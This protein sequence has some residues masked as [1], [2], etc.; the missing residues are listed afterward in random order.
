MSVWVGRRGNFCLP[1]E[2]KAQHPEATS[3]SANVLRRHT[4]RNVLQIRGVNDKKGKDNSM[5]AKIARTVLVKEKPD[6]FHEPGWQGS[7]CRIVETRMC[8][9]FS[10]YYLLLI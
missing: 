7:L 1:H 6:H 3:S 4:N 10:I 9:T 2:K 8:T 5:Y